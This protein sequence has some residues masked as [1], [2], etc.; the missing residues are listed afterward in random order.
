MFI[1]FKEE[2]MAGKD[3]SATEAEARNRSD[4]MLKSIAGKVLSA[5]IEA[6]TARYPVAS[7]RWAEQGNKDIFI[8]FVLDVV[9]LGNGLRLCPNLPDMLMNADDQMKERLFEMFKTAVAG[10]TATTVS[11]RQAA[12]EKAEP[13]EENTPEADPETKPE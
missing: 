7:S 2:K 11:K 9:E 6:I 13:A 10:R 8:E 12:A 1:F 5:E 4:K 3:I